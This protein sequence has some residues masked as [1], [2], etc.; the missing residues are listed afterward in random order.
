MSI[1]GA[2]RWSQRQKLCRLAR[3]SCEASLVRRALAV[4][5]LARGRGVGQVAEALSAARSTVYL[6]A[7]WFRE[8]GIDALLEERRGSER[9]TVTE[10]VLKEME[11][12]L[13][14]TPQTL[15]YLRSRWSS[16]LL[17]HELRVRTGVA[18]H[19]STVRRALGGNDWVWR[20]ARPTLHIA[21]PRKKQRMRAIRRA[22]A[23]RERGVEVFYQDEADVDLNPRI[24]PAWRR[25]GG[26]YQEAVPTPGKNCKAYVAGALHARTGRVIWVGGLRKDSALFI[27]QLAALEQAYPS[28]RRLL[29][30]LDNY[31]VHKSHKV[32][33]WLASHP[34]IELLFQPAYHPWVNR[35]ERLWKAMH[36]TV[37]RNHRCR[38]LEELCAH[39]ARFLEVVQPFPGAGHACATMAV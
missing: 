36:D 3:K 35:I 20:R 18:I 32:N 25:R 38:T 19:P 10:K 7:R 6:W 5:Q 11:S 24:G 28:A 27:E 4:V 9:R 1:V 29:L 17:A 33:T 16:E 30:I 26:A 15:G 8:G 21:D 23:R 13:E 31:G 14:T 37:T 2:I 34:R 39:V 22:L 12:L